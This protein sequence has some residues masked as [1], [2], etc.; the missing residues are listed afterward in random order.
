MSDV[1]IKGNVGF[2]SQR[3]SNAQKGK[4]EWYAEC[5]DYVI[6]AGLDASRQKRLEDKYN[7]LNGLISDD[8]YKKILNPYNATKDSNK[9]FPA[10]MRNYDMMR[11]I[12]RRYVSEYIKSP[13]D[14]IVGANNPDIVFAKDAQLRQE[15]TRLFEVKMSENINKSYEEFIKN[16]GD[17]KDFNPE[18]SIN[19]EEELEK[20]NNNYID[21]TSKQAQELLKVIDDITESEVLYSQAYFDWVSIGECFTYSDVIDNKLIKR[22]VSPIDAMPVPNDNMFV[23]DHD[24]FASRRKLTYQQIID[25]FDEYFTEK[26]RKYLEDLYGNEAGGNADITFE[27]YK[28]YYP[29]VFE[30]FSNYERDLFTR[31]NVFSR[32]SNGALIDVYHATWRGEKKQGVLTYVNSGILTQRIVE[33]GYKLMPELGDVSIDYTYEPQVYECVRIGS[34]YDAVYPY[35]ARAIAYNRG[36]KLPYNGLTELLK[37]FGEFS[38]VGIV[39][40][41]QVFNNIVNYH[42]EMLIAKNKGNVLM[43]PKSLL[44]GNAE[45]TIH[46]M[47]ADGVLY[48]DDE[49]DSNMLKSQQIRSIQNNIAQDISAYTD[50]IERIETKAKEQVDMTPQRYGSIADSAGRGTTQEAISRGSMGTVVVE[51]LFDSMRERDYARDLDFTKLAWVDGLNTSYRDV[52]NN[53]KYVSLDVGTHVYADYIIKAKSSVK[54]KEKL[55]QLKQFAFSAA[56]NGNMDMALA[57]ITG[58]NVS[59]IKELIMNFQEIQNKS[60]ENLKAQDQQLEQMKQEFEFKKIAAQGEQDRA[61]IQLEKQ[62]DAQIEGIKLTNKVD[63]TPTPFTSDDGKESVARERN[64][65]AR[66]GNMLKFESAERDRQVKLKELASKERIAKTNKNKY[67]R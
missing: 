40:P 67:D 18:D 14:F 35:K 52:E 10:D 34:R 17:G 66:D 27:E 24:M 5:C 45:K 31:E 51:F 65:V 7:I 54:E 46:K 48:L 33:D 12:I 38:I 37:G 2:P 61:N 23:E 49:E 53:L 64:Q 28:N 25:E 11:G 42:R 62:L 4:A 36:G 13:H 8:I 19:I 59:A 26:D 55:D 9:R 15:A 43:M 21:S 60:Q 6:G 32:E 44:G 57:A 58:D 22:V 1:N 56:Q 50:L 16:G 47:A 30:K 20:F 39:A 3:V 41:Y 29:D 63:V